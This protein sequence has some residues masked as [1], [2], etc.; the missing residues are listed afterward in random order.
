VVLGLSLVRVGGV[1][2]HEI[3]TFLGLEHPSLGAHTVWEF[4][5][6]GED[7]PLLTHMVLGVSY[8]RLISGMFSCMVHIYP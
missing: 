4:F 8:P 6:N 1:V 7:F 5:H 3:S 2:C